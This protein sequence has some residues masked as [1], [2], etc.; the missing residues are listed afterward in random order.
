M[1]RNTMTWSNE[2]SMQEDMT[3]T[4][5][6]HIAAPS[7]VLRAR[8]DRETGST[9]P[10]GD[11]PFELAAEPRHLLFQQNDV[12]LHLHLM[13]D[14]E[15]WMTVVVGQIV[16]LDREAGEI[17]GRRVDL[18]AS[19]EIVDSGTSN[20]LGEFQLTAAVDGP[21]ELLLHLEGGRSVVVTVDEMVHEL[22]DLLMTA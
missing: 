16:S 19:T 10:A 1:D 15:R 14:T 22:E 2:H 20:G 13:L 7:A 17:A 8:L 9:T 21:V 11:F 18:M 3:M 4:Q 5:H 12:G 6:I